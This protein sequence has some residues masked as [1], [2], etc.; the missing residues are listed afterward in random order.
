MEWWKL[1]TRDLSSLES[2]DIHPQ[3][4][5]TDFLVHLEPFL[6]LERELTEPG[7]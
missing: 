7:K 1:P 5:T 3:I 6:N 4:Y 2:Y